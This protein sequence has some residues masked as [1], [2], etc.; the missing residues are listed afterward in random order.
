MKVFSFDCPPKGIQF[1]VIYVHNDK[2]WSHTCRMWGD[3]MERYD[4]TT[5]NWRELVIADN[6][7]L[8]FISN[9]QEPLT[10]KVITL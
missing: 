2:V 9:L 1:I 4:S 7:D 3:I 10:P 8:K 5:D 6:I